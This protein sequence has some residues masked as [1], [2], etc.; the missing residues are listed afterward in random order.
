MDDSRTCAVTGMRIE[1]HAANL[2]KLNAVTA[3]VYLLLGG[4]AALLIAFTRWHAIQLL[5]AEWYY[6]LLTFHGT[7]MLV[8]WIVFFEAAGIVFAS[9]VVLNSRQAY[10]WVAYASY[11]LMLVGSLMANWAMLFTEYEQAAVMFTAYPP[12]KA[13]PAFYLGIIL[14]AVGALVF[15]LLFFANVYNARRERTHTGPVPLFTYGIAAAATIGVFT[16]IHGAMAMIPAFLWS[17]GLIANLDPGTYRLAFWGFGHPAQQINLCAM[18]AIWY[19]LST[20][21]VGG[22]PL[23]E[24]ICRTAFVLYVLFINLGSAHHL[25][26]DPAFGT[27]WKIF[28]TSYAMYLAVFASL[29]HALSVPATVEIAQRKRGHRNGLFEWIRKAPW[30]NPAFAALALSLVI[31]GFLGGI[32]GVIIGTEQINL[33]AHN[34]MRLPG[35]FHATVVGGTTLAFMGLTYYVIPLLF[36]REWWSVRLSK[37]QPYLFAGG[38]TLMSLSMTSL[39]MMGMPRR[40]WDMEF[41][42]SVLPGT[43]MN[44]MAHVVMVGMG[45]GALVAVASVVIFAGNAVATLLLGK[46]VENGVP[47]FPP[48]NLPSAATEAV[49]E[50]SPRPGFAAPGVFALAIVFLLTFVAMYTANWLHLTRAW[51]IR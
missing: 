38:I 16:L 41:T 14:F 44:G 5:P 45:L 33:R 47:S 1:R 10:P 19:G 34:T 11:G 51:E 32:S 30:G 39:G 25:L 2:I 20:F 42:G 36:Q 48:V 18:V 27:T 24:K 21:T 3:V 28:N 49:P 12:L 46:R 22:V 40:H 4:I 23:N 26:V 9:T 6:R 29:L 31:F 43:L 50:E 15:C 37:W 35:H 7:N 17:I 8:F 13:H